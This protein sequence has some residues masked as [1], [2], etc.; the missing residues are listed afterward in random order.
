MAT[1]PVIPVPTLD[2]QIVNTQNAE[3]AYL[4]ANAAV[5]KIEDDIATATAPLADAQAALTA[6]KTTFD[7]QLDALAS[8][9]QASK[10]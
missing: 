9:A 3:A 2:E 4:S 7:T 10:V 6:A 8:I 5:K 1:S